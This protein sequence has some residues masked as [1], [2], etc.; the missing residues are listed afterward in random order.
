[1]KNVI[2]HSLATDED[3][4]LEESQRSLCLPDEILIILIILKV[5]GGRV[6]GKIVNA[7][8]FFIVVFSNIY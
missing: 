6:D 7:V 4:V 1:M 5:P 3:K 8:I 2:E